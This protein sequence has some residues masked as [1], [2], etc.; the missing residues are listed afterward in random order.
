L[1][2][3]CWTN[4]WLCC[5]H[6]SN[7]IA[8]LILQPTDGIVNNAD[9]IAPVSFFND[10]KALWLHINDRKRRRSA[11]I[12]LVSMFFGMVLELAGVGTIFSAITILLGDNG[13]TLAVAMRTT[14]SRF[15]G[16]D[17]TRLVAFAMITLVLLFTLKVL[18][19]THVV[20]SV[21]K[22]SYSLQADLSRELYAN[23]LNQPYEY[24]L[25]RNSERL[26]NTVN[27]EARDAATTV[28]STLTLFAE[29]LV[30]MGL[31]AILVLVSPAI[32]LAIAAVTVAAGIM[33]I[34]H[35]RLKLAN[36]GQLARE[37]QALRMKSLRQGFD[38]YKE[39]RLRG[40]VNTAVAD[41]DVNN[42]ANADAA[43]HFAALSVLPRFWMEWLG[44]AGLA[45]VVLALEFKA[46]GNRSVLPL[47]GLIGA[48][49]FRLLPSLSRIVGG[50]QT[51][52][53]YAP[54]LHNIAHE[55]NAQ[56]AQE[57][58]KPAGKVPFANEIAFHKVSYVY[59]KNEDAVVRDFSLR[60][61]QGTFVGVVGPS[62]AGKSTVIN[63]L[64]G[65]VEP[66]TGTVT[67]DGLPI[68][69]GIADWQSRIGYV[70]QTVF[71][72]DDTLRRNIAFGSADIEIDDARVLAA[73][74]AAQLDL[75]SQNTG[76]SL[77]VQLGDRG[78]RLSGGQR[79]RIA[80]ARALYFKPELLVLDEGTSALDVETE[81]GIMNTLR[82]LR[83]SMT[84]IVASHRAS[85]LAGSDQIIHVTEDTDVT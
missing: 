75:S 20:N 41:F 12:L 80:I 84:I 17:Q 57:S 29:V 10:L 14:L 45:A 27:N 82:A 68:S 23:Y 85:A 56:T 74:A 19:Q 8:K 16:V 59:P 42:Q 39:I 1:Q 65:F 44:V 50:L 15:F 54:T 69:T 48:V 72:A 2:K 3:W 38:G 21:A 64:L 71:I 61:P 76:N 83:G 25:L 6:N 13:G 81:T 55:L 11:V 36:W 37:H 5:I 58:E 9:Q 31:V 7:A 24:H 49:A 79:Q 46:P 33:M 77:D 53:F 32:G 18:F 60:I 67:V 70:P 22:F 35:N 28:N 47:L 34:R 43:R 40:L 52:R 78:V 73:L 30:A 63:L 51:L 4:N 26:I 62:G 66:T